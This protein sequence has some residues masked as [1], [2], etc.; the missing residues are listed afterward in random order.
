MPEQTAPYPQINTSGYPLIIPELGV[1]VGTGEV[2]NHHLPIT[3][4][5]PVPDRKTTKPAKGTDQEGAAR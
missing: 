3:G 5:E 1:T 4:F 2:I